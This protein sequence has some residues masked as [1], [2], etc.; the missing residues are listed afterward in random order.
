[1]LTKICE[2]IFD[3]L[4]LSIW[5]CGGAD[6]WWHRRWATV[7]VL[8]IVIVACGVLL[9]AV[10]TRIIVLHGVGVRV[11]IAARRWGWTAAPALVVVAIVLFIAV[12][13]V[14]V[15]LLLLLLVEHSLICAVVTVL[16]VGVTVL[17]LLHVTV[18]VLLGLFP[19]NLAGIAEICVEYWVVVAS[20][21]VRVRAWVVVLLRWRRST[22]IGRARVVLL[23]TV[24]GRWVAWNCSSLYEVIVRK[25]F[26]TKRRSKNYGEKYA[27]VLIRF[28]S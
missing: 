25:W 24:A 16:H 1:M 20:R 26:T 8:V 4:L 5:S 14:T 15:L 23:V 19:L 11:L 17:W 22:T 9:V 10:H 7:T 6:V 28:F 13:L 18:A 21:W 12:V 27:F 3:Y 2:S